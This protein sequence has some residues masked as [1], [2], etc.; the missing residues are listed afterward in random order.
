MAWKKKNKRPTEAVDKTVSPGKTV[1]AAPQSEQILRRQLSYRIGNMQGVGRRNYQEDSFSFVNALDVTAIREKGL[2]AIMADGMGGMADGKLASQ[3]VTET[4]REEFLRLA[5]W[6]DPVGQLR[7]SVIRAGEE[8]FAKLRGEGGSTV[9]V[10]LFFKEQLWFASVGDSALFLLRDGELLRLN[11]EQNVL[12]EYYLDTV[13]RGSMNPIP[14]RRNPEKDA[15][16]Q[17]LGMPVLEEIDMLLRPL[18]L[19]EGDKLLLC[20]DGVADMVPDPLLRECMLLPEPTAICAALEQ[21]VLAAGNP[22]Q[23]NYT[24]LLVQCGY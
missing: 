19:H 14:A 9:V 12:N 6:K 5:P 16:T 15:L 17:F 18:P 11:R 3:T 21:A 24:A 10:C 20:S 7:D 22:Y 23:D 8:V 4:L 1:P 2:L 13:C